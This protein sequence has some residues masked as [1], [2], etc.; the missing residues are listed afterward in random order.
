MLARVSL[1]TVLLWGLCLAG[2]MFGQS[3]F[4]VMP[5]QVPGLDVYGPE[6]PEFSRH[7][8]DLG[9]DVK[10]DN[11]TDAFLSHAI[12]VRNASNRPI[13]KFVVR[14]EY[15]NPAGKPY[16]ENQWQ[17]SKPGFQPGAA[18]LVTVSRTVTEA[19]RSHWPKEVLERFITG[20]VVDA[21]L[22][23]PTVLVS[24]DA[25]L[26]AD[27]EFFGPDVSGAWKMLTEEQEFIR[28]TRLELE[29]IGADMGAIQK[30]LDEVYQPFVDRKPIPGEG[31]G[32]TMARQQMFS[33]LSF[34]YKGG[35]ESLRATLEARFGEGTL[36]ALRRKP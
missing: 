17:E 26:F 34:A 18:Q 27:G 22:R 36:V 12:V 7:I 9:V 2:A 21:I 5:S 35:Y 1:R 15:L 3:G 10:G 14:F 11:A 6:A 16:S 28:S 20:S 13:S 23:S 30:K 8:S 29:R 31:F 19:I 4:V 33:T 25:V 24:L 32:V